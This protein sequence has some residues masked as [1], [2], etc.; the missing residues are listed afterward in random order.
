MRN[1]FVVSAVILLCASDARAARPLTT[2]DASLQDAKACQVELWTVRA[3]DGREDWALP[4]CNVTG[5]LELALGAARSVADGERHTL[6]VVQAKTLFKSVEPNGWG[7]GLV[8]GDRFRAGQPNGDLYAFLPASLSL[9]EDQF[10]VHAN[11]GWLRRDEGR[12]H[13]T[14]WAVATEGRLG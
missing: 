4:A 3:H 11:L 2:D 1:R 5:N 8:L 13:R 9:R 6:G 10:F 7:A 12:R 14:T